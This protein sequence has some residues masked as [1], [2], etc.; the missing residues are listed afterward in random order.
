MTIKLST[1]IISLNLS[2]TQSICHYIDMSPSVPVSAFLHV[3]VELSVCPSV[4]RFVGLCVC[5]CVCLPASVYYFLFLY[6]FVFPISPSLSHLSVLM[7]QYVSVCLSLA[8]SQSGPPYLSLSLSNSLFPPVSLL[9]STAMG[10]SWGTLRTLAQCHLRWREFVAAL[11]Q[12]LSMTRTAV[13][14]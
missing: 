8:I 4:Y 1:I 5:L 11:V 2:L 7:S 13:S 3:T 14:K 12:Q 6:L 10:H 9:P